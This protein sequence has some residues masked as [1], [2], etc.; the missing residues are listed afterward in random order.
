MIINE[1]VSR[2]NGKYCDTDGAY[3]GQ[4]MDLMHQYCVEILGIQDLSVLAAPSAQL[5]WNNFQNV[6]GHELFD[7]IE[8]TPTGVPQEGDIMLWTNLPYGHVAIFIEGDAN[9]FKS[10]DQ[11]YPTGSPC[12]IQAHTYANVGGWLRLKQN[13]NQTL[14]VQIDALRLERDKN[15]NMFTAVCEAL[16]VGANVDAA[17]A[18]AKKLVGNDDVLVQKDKQLRDAQKQIDDL[19]RELLD[20]TVSH[21]ALED[22]YNALQDKFNADTVTISTLKDKLE[23]LEAQI[24]AP[25]RKGWKAALVALIDRF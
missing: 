23:L 22:S 13:A 21:N 11:N 9:S 24:L 25:V 12:H 20:V 10:F 17:V 3:G 1:F 18:E 5:V 6:K 4:C 8:N 19:K 15:W 2:W 7:K 14:Q 16:G